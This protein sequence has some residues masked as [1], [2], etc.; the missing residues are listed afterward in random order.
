[1]PCPYFVP[2]AQLAWPSAPKLPL[3]DA[4][5]GVCGA[6]AGNP[7]DPVIAVQR[8]LCNLGYARG[9]CSHFPDAD[10]ADAVR[11]AVARDDAGLIGI[12]WVVE[13]DHHPLAHGPLEYSVASAAFVTP[14]STEAVRRLAAAYVASYLRRKTRS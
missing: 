2:M 4:Y 10:V 11:F 7:I 6:E 8:D 13:K 3:G 1:M 12:S 9:R 5:T 14:Q